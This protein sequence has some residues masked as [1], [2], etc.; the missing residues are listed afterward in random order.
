M[1]YVYEREVSRF[2]SAAP[3]S[4]F[5][6]AKLSIGSETRSIPATAKKS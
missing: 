2:L 3:L 6:F 1:M 4:P 5:L